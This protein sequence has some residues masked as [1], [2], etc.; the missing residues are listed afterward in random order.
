MATFLRH[1]PAGLFAYSARQW[2]SRSLSSKITS[3]SANAIFVGYSPIRLGSIGTKTVTRIEATQLSSSVTGPSFPSEDLP[4]YSDKQLSAPTS[5]LLRNTPIRIINPCV[6]VSRGGC[7][8]E[9]ELVNRGNELRRVFVEGAFHKTIE[10]TAVSGPLKGDVFR[11]TLL[12]S[13]MLDSDVENDT[14][15]VK[16]IRARSSEASSGA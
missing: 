5:V 7:R 4:V 9:V 10:T 6:S 14:V 11:A 15:R 12:L 16:S 3:G 2:L 1:W 13:P 8:S